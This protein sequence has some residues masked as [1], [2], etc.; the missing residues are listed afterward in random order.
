MGRPS[1]REKT[2]ADSRRFI[3]AISEQKGRFLWMPTWDAAAIGHTRHAGK[4]GG[5]PAF[6][7]FETASTVILRFVVNPGGRVW[8]SVQHAVESPRGGRSGRARLDSF[9]RTRRP[10][11]A[12]RVEGWAMQQ[13]MKP[14][15]TTEIRGTSRKISAAFARAAMVAAEEQNGGAMRFPHRVGCPAGD[16]VVPGYGSIN[17]AIAN[18]QAWGKKN[19]F[20]EGVSVRC[21]S[22]RKRGGQGHADRQSLADLLQLRRTCGPSPRRRGSIFRAPDPHGVRDCSH[23]G[24]HI[25]P[26]RQGS[27]A[28]WP[29]SCVLQDVLIRAATP[30]FVAA[31]F[32]AVRAASGSRS[33][34]PSSAFPQLS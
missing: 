30:V 27:K 25:G 34:A 1:V 24:P 11:H 3:A 6:E 8:A 9:P 14:G 15:A 22:I 20:R 13:S 28:L 21:R 19:P 32:P 12:V 18:E 26:P 23:G 2:A 31:E 10:R 5:G 17:R 33:Q 7:D 4:T 29:W 16:G